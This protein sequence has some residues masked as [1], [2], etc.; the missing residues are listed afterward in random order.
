MYLDQDNK[1]VIKAA[2]KPLCEEKVQITNAV[3]VGR[4]S[5]IVCSNRFILPASSCGISIICYQEKDLLCISSLSHIRNTQ[6]CKYSV[7]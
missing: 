1:I 7:Y 4:W 2:G 3:S 6:S 5:F